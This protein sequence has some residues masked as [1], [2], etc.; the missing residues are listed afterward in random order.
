MIPSIRIHIAVLVCDTPIQPILRKYGDYFSIFQDLLRKALK[1]LEI[2]EKFK[3]IMVE[4]SEHQMVDNNRF[5]D[6]EDV[7]AIL[8]T[9]S[10]HDAWADDQWIR[11]LTGNVRET[12]LKHEKPVIGI[13]FGHQI[14]A[15]ALGARVGR[16]EA[17]WE[18]SVEKLTLT[19]T[20]KK[21]FGKDTLASGETSGQARLRE[22]LIGYRAFNK[23]TGILSLMFQSVAQTWLQVQNVKSRVFTCPI[24]CCRYKDTRNTT[25]L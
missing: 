4:F 6:L 14:L 19:E 22:I 11:D 13:C 2:S 25:R 20:G 16:N 21:L 17:G 15:R 18:I 24:E 10:K 5:L 7:D 9:G 12:V 8:L 3:D 23:C 1:D